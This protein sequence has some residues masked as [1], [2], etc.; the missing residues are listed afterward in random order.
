MEEILKKKIL[1]YGVVIEQDENGVY[2][3]H[4]PELPGCHTQ[5]KSAEEALKNAS[6][7]I[8]LCLEHI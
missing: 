1:G 2:I 8:K 4:V 7:A 6:E 3:A 5:G